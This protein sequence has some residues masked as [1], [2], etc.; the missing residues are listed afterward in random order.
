MIT[1]ATDMHA[2]M[3]SVLK[4][5]GGGGKD[6]SLRTHAAKGII[7]G[8]RFKQLLQFLCCSA[9]LRLELLVCSLFLSLRL[10]FSSNS[11]LFIPL[12]LYLP[13]LSVFLPQRKATQGGL[14]DIN[15]LLQ[16]ALEE[17]IKVLSVLK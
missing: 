6:P 14:M 2:D 13:L 15:R 7:L 10:Y 1:Q 4:R 11:L 12:R 3:R 8:H 16:T 17:T 5:K 9:E